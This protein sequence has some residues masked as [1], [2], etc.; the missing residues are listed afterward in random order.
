MAEQ[1]SQRR[2][3]TDIVIAKLDTA[4]TWQWVARAGGAN[5][6]SATPSFVDAQGRVVITGTFAGPTLPLSAATLTAAP[7]AFAFGNTNYTLSAF[8]AVL[9]ANGPLATAAPGRA[10]PWSVYP[11]PARGAIT[12]AGLAPGQPVQVLDLLGRLVLSGT[13]PKQGDLQL[14]LPA[15]LASGLYVVR[16][17]RRR[18]D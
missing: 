18:S 8:T 13:A 12:V 6:E 15:G 9:G 2:A 16:R 1:P 5:N 14:A 10:R 4:G 7:T 3:G 17:A 11:N